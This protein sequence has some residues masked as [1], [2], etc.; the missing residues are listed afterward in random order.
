MQQS[1]V[2]KLSGGEK[3]SGK[4]AASSAAGKG[5]VLR[6]KRRKGKNPCSPKCRFL[7][8]L[9]T[10]CVFCPFIGSATEQARNKIEH[11]PNKAKIKTR[12]KPHKLLTVYNNNFNTGKRNRQALNA[13][14]STFIPTSN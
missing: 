3:L 12:I 10:A 2:N 5:S 9:G 7:A 13:T 8:E 11:K 14:G 6:G 1:S 4:A